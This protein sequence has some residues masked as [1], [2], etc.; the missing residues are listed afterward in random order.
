MTHR[1]IVGF[2]GFAR[3]A[4][5]IDLVIDVRMRAQEAMERMVYLA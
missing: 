5:R 1:L 3:L 4:I 2:Q